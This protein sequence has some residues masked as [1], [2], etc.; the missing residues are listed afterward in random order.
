MRRLIFAS[1]VCMLGVMAMS[2]RANAAPIRLNIEHNAILS[3]KY[4]MGEAQQGKIGLRLRRGLNG[5][6][7]LSPYRTLRLTAHDQNGTVIAK[8]DL[9]MG[10]RQTYAHLDVPPEFAGASNISITLH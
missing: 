1:L 9:R 7:H 2:V 4:S 6:G 5:H 3:A 10:K 8:T